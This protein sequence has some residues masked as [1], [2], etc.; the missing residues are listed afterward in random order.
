MTLEWRTPSKSLSRSLALSNPLAWWW[1]FISLV[2]AANIAVTTSGGNPAR[3]DPQHSMPP[4]ATASA[5]RLLRQCFIHL[6]E[7]PPSFQVA[8]QHDRDDH[9]PTRSHQA[10]QVT[11]AACDWHD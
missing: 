3:N 5:K 8:A 4:P 6:I 1:G 9:S 2:S 10:A 7:L 11:P